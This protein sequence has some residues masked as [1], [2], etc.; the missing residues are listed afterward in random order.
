M[1]GL[2][3]PKNMPR[4]NPAISIEDLARAK[5]QEVAFRGDS[6]HPTD[7]PRSM[8]LTARLIEGHPD[9][10]PGLREALLD[11][12]VRGALLADLERDDDAITDSILEGDDCPIIG[13]AVIKILS[14][15]YAAK[16]TD[17]EGFLIL[18]FKPVSTHL[19]IFRSAQSA[20]Q[21]MQVHAL[22]P[23]LDAIIA[24]P[25]QAPFHGH[26][27]GWSKLSW[28]LRRILLGTGERR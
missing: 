8:Q 7:A 15:L 20:H 5:G 10:I 18:S 22:D 1:P 13:S 16:A 28:H 12:H 6:L 19:D 3:S 21:R 2:L 25:W 11:P 23:D 26:A 4:R 14:A 9:D 24:R 27:H 17:F